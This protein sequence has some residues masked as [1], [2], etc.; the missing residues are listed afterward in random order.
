MPYRCRCRAS[1]SSR[2]ACASVRTGTGPSAAAMPPT[3]SRVIR[4][5]LAPNRAALSA[6]NTPAGPAPM[7][8]TSAGSAVVTIRP[9]DDA[10]Q[11]AERAGD[12]RTK[13]HIRT[14]DPRPRSGTIGV[15]WSICG[16]ERRPPGDPTCH[17][18]TRGPGRPHRIGPATDRRFRPRPGGRT[19]RDPRRVPRP[20]AR[21]NAAGQG[22]VVVRTRAQQLRS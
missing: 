21:R 14:W 4:V 20:R 3:A 5:V 12:W 7:T 1:R 8:A 13:G 10:N 15:A 11:P 22:L 17:S 16:G 18:G 9:G 2:A 19:A 6:A